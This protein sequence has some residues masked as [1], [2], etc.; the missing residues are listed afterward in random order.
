M[1]QKISLPDQVLDLLA[2]I[3]A[4]LGDVG[5]PLAIQ[6]RHARVLNYSPTYIDLNIPE[7]CDSGSWPDGPLDIKPLVTDRQGE[8]V[9]EVLLW[10]SSGR[11]TLLEQAWFTD[12]P[13][14]A[15]PSM[16]NVRIS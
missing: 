6:A 14:T 3:A 9:G 4:H 16:E 15:W 11:I 12:D 2:A 1:N 7:R 5:Q 13:P 8:P 10:V